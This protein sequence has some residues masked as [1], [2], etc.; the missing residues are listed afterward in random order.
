[1][2]P[3]RIIAHRNRSGTLSVRLRCT[4]A[5]GCCDIATGVTVP[6]A[7]YD[8]RRQRVATSCPEHAA[9]NAAIDTLA[10]KC[11]HIMAER[12][13]IDA[14]TLRA[15][16]TPNTAISRG[17][18]DDTPP[19]DFFAVLD[20]FCREGDQRRHWSRR[21]RQGYETLRSNVAKV[22]PLLRMA[23]IT[24]SFMDTLVASMV[25]RGLHN[26]TIWQR[27][28]L[29]KAVVTWAADNGLYHGDV[30]TK[31]KPHL[32]GSHFEDKEVTY[33]S[34]DELA[35]VEACTLP[36][37]LARV[38]DLFVFGCYTGLRY[39]DIA[40]LRTVDVH[41]NY[42]DVV[43]C[44]TSTHLRIELNRHSRAIIDRYADEGRPDG[45][46]LPQM[47]LNG[48]NADLRK[49]GRLAG[50]NTPFK[51]VHYTGSRRVERV[52]P[53]WQLMSTHMARRTF[54]VSALQL[55]IPAEV[56][57]RWTGHRNF[58]SMRPYFAIVDELKQQSMAKFDTLP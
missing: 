43:T 7:D 28:M 12:P 36:P 20:R 14:A 17:G 52:R 8:T 55:G 47:T 26:T 53:K 3:V 21:T 30:H 38:R 51:S 13:T 41:D 27:L 35:A 49:I 50:I 31:Y 1:M 24:P 19:D 58:A 25:E 9:L 23:D 54:V 11:R 5:A 48:C 16:I 22:D 2:T 18:L 6:A 46:A 40:S 4:L 10:D 44:K 37:H 33:L 32:R 56:I 34:L 57:M 39:S 15:Q 29:L 42:I 45:L